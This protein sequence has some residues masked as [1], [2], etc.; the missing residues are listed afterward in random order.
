MLNAAWVNNLSRGEMRA[1]KL[2][3]EECLEYV[4]ARN[5]IQGYA[6]SLDTSMAEYREAKEIL[7][8]GSLVE[9]F[10]YYA[11]KKV[12]D[13]PA[14]LVKDVVEEMIRAKRN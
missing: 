13:I 2:S 1:A 6:L 4:W 14:K 10:R 5:T 9:A 8:G 7:K 11:S 12:L 3:G